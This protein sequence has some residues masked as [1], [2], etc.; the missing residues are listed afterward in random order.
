MKF[1]IH[2]KSIRHTNSNDF[3]QRWGKKFL[4]QSLFDKNPQL[5]DRI[6]LWNSRKQIVPSALI[7]QPHRYPT[8]PLWIHAFSSFF[9]PN[10]KSLTEISCKKYSITDDSS[11]ILMYTLNTPNLVGFLFPIVGLL[12]IKHWT[13]RKFFL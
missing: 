13:I 3:K 2:H 1:N 10:L 11:F 9:S 6:F 4:P 12:W 5:S 7:F 8:L